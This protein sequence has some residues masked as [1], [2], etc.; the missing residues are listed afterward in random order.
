[1]GIKKKLKLAKWVAT[2]I[3]A[4]AVTGYI[5][6]KAMRPSTIGYK[7]VKAQT[8]DIET[9]YSFSGN[10]VSKNRQKVIAENVMLIKKI[11]VKKGDIVEEGS[12]LATTAD[13]AKLKSKIK[14]EVVNIRAEEN[15]PL[16]AGMEIMD[17]VDFDNLEV[18]FKVDEYD[19]ARLEVGKMATVRIG[20]VDKEF[21]GVISDISKEGQIMNGVTF[22]TASIDI[23]KEDGIRTGMSAEVTLLS[24]NARGAVLL[25]MN[26][27]QFDERNNPYV[28]KLDEKRSIVKAMITTGITD[29]TAVEIKSGVLPGESVYY[30]RSIALEDILFPEGG[31]NAR[32][33]IGGED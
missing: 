10:V 26:V 18:V 19:V 9:Y 31:K 21:K 32:V 6:Y 17:I 8:G 13:G 5:A 16:M 3:I 20:A 30:K 23:E 1:M 15:A 14:G 4:A 11:H 28:L 22:Y 25:P 2:G 24:D 33:Y 27:I 29:G 7:S 12:L